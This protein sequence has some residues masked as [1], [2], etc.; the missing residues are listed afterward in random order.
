MTRASG[1]GLAGAPPALAALLASLEREGVHWS[2][3]R[4]RASLASAQGDID[5]LVEPAAIPRLE[6]ILE[7]NGFVRVPVP[8][9]DVHAAT[10]DREAGAFVWMH[11]Q[12]ALRLAGDE[13]PAEAI[14]SEAVER[15]GITEPGDGWLLWI[16][17]LRALV[18]KGELPARHRTAVM[19]LAKRDPKG[20]PALEALARRHGID[21]VA[22]VAAAA[23]GDWP[24]LLR[25]AVERQPPP[26]TLRRIAR[27]PLRVRGLRRL[28]ERRGLLVAVLGPDGA[29]KSTL[30]E[31]L[32]RN[33][34]LPTRVQYMGL[35]GG[36]LPKA[37]ALRIPGLVFV[38]R[39]AILWFRY[40][41]SAY[42]RA[43]GGIVLFDR[44]TLDG[45]VPS[46]MRLSLAGRVSRRL[47]RH[48]CPMPDL[49]L[50]LDASGGTLHARSGE[51]DAAV[52][53]SWRTAFARLEGRV[54]VLE[55]LDA[56]RP[57]DEVLRDAQALV[58]RRYGDLRLGGWSGRPR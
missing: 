24:G 27:L 35:T 49:V 56:E 36:R 19:D 11:V 37:D 45:A 7:A 40:A 54:P 25:L 18:D 32:R 38:A 21:P 31:G 44:Y 30:V 6:G 22:A 10:Y 23:A 34:P 13:L 42:Y 1:P 28:R 55:K 12:G 2:L 5:V 57:A 8:G 41:R 20:P 29:G 39:V 47:Q 17:L 53:E 14:L 3:L 4:P 16:L 51:Y 9:P 48:A 50:L 46:G 15:D 43:R 52:L 26:S 33:L 58:W